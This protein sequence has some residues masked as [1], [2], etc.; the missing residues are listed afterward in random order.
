M[1]VSIGNLA[2]AEEFCMTSRSKGIGEWEVRE[3]EVGE[4]LVKKCVE[5]GK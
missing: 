3:S 1:C 2:S 4:W 5:V